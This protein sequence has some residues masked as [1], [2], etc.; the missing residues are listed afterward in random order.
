MTGKKREKDG[1]QFNG[2]A[3][4][5]AGRKKSARPL[6]KF[7]YNNYVDVDDWLGEQPAG[8]SASVRRILDAAKRRDERRDR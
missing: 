7:N 5:G 1:R 3:R 6:K 4:E 8:K 2:G